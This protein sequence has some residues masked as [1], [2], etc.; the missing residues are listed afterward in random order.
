MANATGW[1]E[2]LNG[3][4]ITAVF[5]MFDAAFMGWTVAILFVVYQIM[6]YI[7]TRNA[8]ICWVTGL[9]FA[10]LY[11]V[12]SSQAILGYLRIESVQVIFVILVFELAG[13]LYALIW[14]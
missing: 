9:F 8:T 10:S 7:K 1:S 4:I 14:K 11:V 3:Q 5:T 2:L 6:L 13:I 12:A